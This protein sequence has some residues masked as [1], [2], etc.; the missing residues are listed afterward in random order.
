MSKTP[1][2]RYSQDAVCSRTALAGVQIARPECCPGS[3]QP[4]R[5][6]TS[7]QSGMDPTVDPRRQLSEKP[8]ERKWD[9]AWPLGGKSLMSNPSPDHMLLVKP[10]DSAA[11]TAGV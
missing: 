2:A 6:Q 11:W 3:A 8:Q 10:P 4:G 9:L 7:G 1:D 5:F